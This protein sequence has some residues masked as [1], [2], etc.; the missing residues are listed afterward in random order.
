[1]KL[2]RR[3]FLHLAASAA[4]LPVMSRIAT[5]RTYPSRPITMIVPYPAG[6]PTDTIARYSPRHAGLARAAG[7]HRK[8]GRRGRHTVSAES[9]RGWRWLYAGHRA[10]GL[11]R[12]QRGDLFAALRLAV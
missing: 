5:A 7:H 2:P 3:R 1:M 4:A 8:R 9:P 12:R 6:G 11:A 10:L